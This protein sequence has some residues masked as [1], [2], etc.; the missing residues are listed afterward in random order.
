MK[1]LI[2]N[3]RVID[4]AN[5]I[6]KISD[7]LIVDGKI[8]KIS[9]KISEAAEIIDAS[10]FIVAPGLIDM[11]VHLREPGR[12]DKETILTA[13]RAAAR[14]GFTSILGMPNTDPVLDDQTAVEF[15]LSRAKSAAVN[16]FT[17]GSATRGQ[18]GKELSDMWELKNSGVIAISDDGRTIASADVLNKVLK[19]SRM[20]NL[21][22]LSHAEEPSM[23]GVMHEGFVSTELGLEG[24]P[25]IA[26]DIIVARE[27]IIAEYN[28]AQI[29][30]CHGTTK[31]TMDMVASAKKKGLK[32]SLET[33]P[34]YF[35]LTDE[36]VRGYNQNAKV[37]PPLRSQEHVNAVINALKKDVIDVIAT[38]HAPHLLSEKYVEFDDAATGF[39]GLET[40][41]PVVMNNLVHSKILTLPQAI[42]K[43]TVNPSR[44]LNIPKGTLSAGA[45]ADI[46]IIDMER[47]ETVNVN[48]FESRGKNTPFA[49]FKLKGVP[50]MTIVDG[51]IIMKDR[52]VIV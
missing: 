37:N 29:H 7:L 21:P 4:P 28:N 9:Q 36:S 2:K 38:D 22:Y 39:S 24:K 27:I 49:G 13:S 10:G 43:M 12:E 40:A 51:K 45:D 30:F 31:G 33:C 46:T 52:K 34:C 44:I 18:Q 11:H 14:G 48:D 3:G 32:I 17:T 23:K 20:L 26:E 15:V 50:V 8:A 42:A 41:V 1:L 19:Y 25:S 5:N 16:I 35:S 47:E 6:D